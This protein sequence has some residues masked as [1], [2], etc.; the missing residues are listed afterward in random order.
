MKILCPVVR[1]PLVLLPDRGEGDERG[2]GRLGTAR[3]LTRPARQVS[4][5]L[6]GVPGV[7]PKS[8]NAC[9]TTIAAEARAHGAVQVEAVS[10]GAPSTART[11]LMGAPIEARIVYARGGDMQVRQARITCR[12]NTQGRVVALL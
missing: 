5:P 3:N 10:A 9:R 1:L 11:G 8:V 7:S 2:T 6:T 12:L 4:R